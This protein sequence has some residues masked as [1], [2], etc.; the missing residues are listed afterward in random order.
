MV[1]RYKII[2]GLRLQHEAQEKKDIVK[3]FTSKISKGNF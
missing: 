1:E 2:S 3:L